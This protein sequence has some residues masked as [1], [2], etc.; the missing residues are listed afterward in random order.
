MKIAGDFTSMDA[1]RTY[2]EVNSF[3]LSLQTSMQASPFEP[4]HFNTRF[5][6]LINSSPTLPTGEQQASSINPTAT[7]TQERASP[8]HDTL[9]AL[10]GEIIGE[11]VRL[12]ATDTENADQDS[13]VT[14]RPIPMQATITSRLVHYE[15]EE[16]YFSSSGTVATEDGR[17]IS[18]SLDLSMQRTTTESMEVSIQGGPL[19][20]YLLD[21]LILSF[22]GGPPAFSSTSFLFDLD[23]DGQKDNIAALQPGC[24]FLAFDQNNDG[25]INDGMELFG[26]QSG[27]GFTDLAV[28]DTDKNLWIDENDAIFNSLSIWRPNDKGEPTMQS[29]KEAGVGAISLSHAGTEFTLQGSS[30][31]VIAQVA[32]NGIFLTEDG[33]VRS[34]QEVD[35]AIDDTKQPSDEDTPSSMA[36]TFRA[37][38]KLRMI[39]AMQ[40]MRARLM[41]ARQ[42]LESPFQHFPF[43]TEHLQPSIAGTNLWEQ[44][45]EEVTPDETITTGTSDQIPPEPAPE[46][47][48]AR[49]ITNEQLQHDSIIQPLLSLHEM[50]NFTWQGTLQRWKNYHFRNI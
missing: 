45:A 16:V 15:R 47:L 22:T 43:T 2:T 5:R 11:P 34:L 12:L 9:R 25:V 21:P 27:N 33:E 29:L 39:V 31:E 40:R 7:P 32:A 14:N 36:D 18:F 37:L 30:G 13:E 17:E 41:V 48:Q 19:T 3:S 23:C 20:K 50:Q 1:T 38:V 26:P 24:G 44:R 28:F 42:R 4:D 35:L 46:E 49:E 8:S 10:T 6:C